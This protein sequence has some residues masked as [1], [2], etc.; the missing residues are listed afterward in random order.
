MF[1]H[2]IIDANLIRLY[3]IHSK[4]VAGDPT[5][6]LGEEIV[7]KDE[8]TGK[9]YKQDSTELTEEE[10]AQVVTTYPYY[11]WAIEE[12]GEGYFASNNF[13]WDR[14][15]NIEIKGMITLGGDSRNILRVLN[16]TGEEV[17]NIGNYTM[18]NIQ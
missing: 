9:Y 10:A 3:A 18:T 7:T 17:V 6:Y 13:N 12:K 11:K 16:S 14:D 2:G 4:D 15:G 1:H 8:S 5:Y